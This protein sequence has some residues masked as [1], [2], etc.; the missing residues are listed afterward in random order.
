MTQKNREEDLNRKI[1]G[2]LVNCLQKL[3]KETARLRTSLEG[4]EQAQK[5]LQS[6]LAGEQAAM[7]GLFF[8]G[9]GGNWRKKFDRGD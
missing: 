4:I 3:S 2:R 1:K 6:I 8:A 7:P 5:E 9:K